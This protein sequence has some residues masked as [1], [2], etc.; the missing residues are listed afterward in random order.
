MIGELGFIGL[1]R[2]FLINDVL[3]EMH[4]CV[5]AGMHE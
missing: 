4:E 2:I 1:G 5:N 3:G